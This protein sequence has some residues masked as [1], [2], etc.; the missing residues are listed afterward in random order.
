[1]KKQLLISLLALGGLA[2]ANAGEA[3]L[4]RFPATNGT[5]VV[6]SYAG[7]LYK[8]RLRQNEQTGSG[9]CLFIEIDVW[10]SNA[11]IADLLRLRWAHGEE[12]RDT[13]RCEQ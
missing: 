10:L 1:M 8:V 5:E 12:K 3:R 13:K 4:L 7:D 9:V 2:G 11:R 6:F